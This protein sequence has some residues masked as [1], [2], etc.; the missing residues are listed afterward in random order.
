MSRL[1]RIVDDGT[2]SDVWSLKP[3]VGYSI[4]RGPTWGTKIMG[5]A[6]LMIKNPNILTS[7]HG[8]DSDDGD[9]ALI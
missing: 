7:R 5:E 2:P 6:P 3:H 9:R 4:R 8:T 1:R